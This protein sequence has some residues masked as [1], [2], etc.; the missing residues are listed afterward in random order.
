MCDDCVHGEGMYLRRDPGGNLS[1]NN[2]GSCQ[3]SPASYDRTGAVQS[4]TDRVNAHFLRGSEPDLGKEAE[5]GKY[6]SGDC[7][8]GDLRL[9]WN[10][11]SAIFQTGEAVVIGDVI[12]VLEGQEISEG[13]LAVEIRPE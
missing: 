10:L 9:S 8:R 5:S 12:L 3:G 7:D 6:A 4:V 1:G 13:S 11:G 2:H